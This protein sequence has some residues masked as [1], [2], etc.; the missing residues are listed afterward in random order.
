[1]AEKIARTG[2][3]RDD[4]DYLYFIKQGDVWRVRRKAFG[5]PTGKPELIASPG[6]EMNP[7]YVYFLDAD[8]DIAA[9]K[10]AVGVA[11]AARARDSVEV[12]QPQQE[13][14]QPAAKELLYTLFPELD[15]PASTVSIRLVQDEAT[16]LFNAVTDVRSFDGLTPRQLEELLAEV[17]RQDGYEAYLTPA[18]RDGGRDVIAVKPGTLPILVVAEAKKMALVEPALVL[19]LYGVVSRDKANMGLLATTGRFSSTTREMTQKTWGCWM[20]L[21]DGEEFASWIRTLRGTK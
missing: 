13:D 16:R 7:Q 2:I 10:R 1:M 15:V 6:I 12:T 20:A 5:V 21:R 9:A 8:G 4:A 11:E 18:T 3:R 17:F 19:S 14:G